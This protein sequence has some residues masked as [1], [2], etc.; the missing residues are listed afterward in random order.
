MSRIKGVQDNEAGL[1][2]RA[3]FWMAKKRLKKV[4]LG[5]RVR[6]LDPSLMKPSLWM[7]L[8][9]AKARAVDGRIKELVQLKV[10]AMVGCPF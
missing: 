4:P 7:D 5:T 6:A 8:N 9:T 2:A 1:T 10:A 3:I